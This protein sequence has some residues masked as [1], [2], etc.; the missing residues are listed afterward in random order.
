MAIRGPAVIVAKPRAIPLPVIIVEKAAKAY[1]LT[2]NLEVRRLFQWLGGRLRFAAQGEARRESVVLRDVSFSLSAGESLGIIGNNGA[3]K[4]TLLRLLGGITLPTRGRVRV[5]GR[6]SSL[7]ALGAGFHPELTGRENLLLNCSLMGL[8]REETKDKIER[9]VEF[10]ELDDYIDVA[11]KR[12]SSGMLARLGFSVAVFL[13][14]D[15][16]LIDEVL[17]VGDYRF[18]VKSSSALRELAGRATLVL[19][20]HDLA[21]VE[22]LCQRVIWLEQGR[23]VADGPSVSVIHEYISAQQRSVIATPV[24]EDDRPQYRGIAPGPHDADGFRVTKQ[25]LDETVLVHCIGTYDAHGQPSAEFSVGDTVVV[26]AHL[27]V[28]KPTA[29]LRMVVGIIDTLSGAVVTAGDNQLVSEPESFHGHTIVECRFPEI[30]LRPRNYGVYVGISNPKAMMP[31][32]V[33]QDVDARFFVLGARRDAGRH[34]YA[35]QAD[36]VFT[37]G[38]QMRYLEMNIPLDSS[39]HHQHPDAKSLVKP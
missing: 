3:G 26:R 6:L 35:P 28:T 34:Y 31:L 10:A 25:I 21:A 29:D 17:G 22:R 27:A 5:E 12:Y 7:I 18:Q 14:P 33:W 4:T 9:M 13:D 24:E 2:P 30:A 15:I 11:I 38:V 1:P 39:L 8:N 23:V 36:L 19:V 37:P 32:N 16:I 20:S